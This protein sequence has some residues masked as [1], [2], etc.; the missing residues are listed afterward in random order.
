[1]LQGDGF[2]YSKERRGDTC[3]SLQRG[4]DMHRGDLG[5]AFVEI[6]VTL[7]LLTQRPLPN[8]NLSFGVNKKGKLHP[9]LDGVM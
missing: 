9:L 6:E 1:M 2:T 7:R 4:E 3:F 5:V 8:L